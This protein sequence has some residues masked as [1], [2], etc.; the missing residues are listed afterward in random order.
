MIGAA[1]PAVEKPLEKPA[2]EKLVPGRIL[3]LGKTVD[4]V[5]LKPPKDFNGYFPFTPPKTVEAWEKRAADLRRQVQ[6]AV[7]LF[8]MPPRDVPPKATVHGL[9]ERDDFTVER[10]FFESF[11]GC[12]VTGSLFKPKG[13]TGKMPAV[14]CP[15]GHWT[16]GR[17][18]VE[19][20]ANI[21]K[22]LADGSEK[23]EVSGRYP[24]Q[25][26]CVQLARMGCVVFHYDMLGYADSQQV[27]YER[28]HKFNKRD[29]EMEGPGKWSFYSPEAEARL[30]SIMGVQTWNSL[31]AFDW[32][33]ARDDVDAA[34]IAVTGASGGGTQT[35]LL[36]ALEPRIAAAFPAVMV[37]TA[38]QG[39]CTCENCCYLRVGTGNIELA[40]LTAPRPLGMT[41]AN[42][43][44]KEMETKG[45]PELRELYK[46]LGRADRVKLFPALQY[47]HN[48]NRVSR[49]AMYGFFNEHLKLGHT[50]PVDDRDFEPLTREELTVWNE[51][52]PA[53]PT[54]P[55]TERKV[56][57][58]FAELTCGEA[59]QKEDIVR[60]ALRTL[61][62]REPPKKGEVTW[63][64]ERVGEREVVLPSGKKVS[65]QWKHGL[66]ANNTTGEV[67]PA[68]ILEPNRENA[69][70]DTYILVNADKK[71]TLDDLIRLK[72]TPEYLFDARL[73][74]IDIF[75]QGEFT[76]DAVSLEKTPK[77]KNDRDY[78][79]FTYGY[80]EPLV[81]S[82][83]HDIWNVLSGLSTL[84]VE[85]KSIAIFSDV[86]VVGLLSAATMMNAC[87]DVDATDVKHRVNDMQ[88]FD[89]VSF[90]P[91]LEKY[92]GT[93]RLNEFLNQQLGARHR[94]ELIEQQK[95]RKSSK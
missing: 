31:R 53:P 71:V 58:G 65:L 14:L 90:L 1:D 62:L 39:G 46:L 70:R 73:V 78:A 81:V 75:G 26:R 16:N 91:G 34:R 35:F 36:S 21:K 84:N 25:A 23:Y 87:G 59:A 51:K 12:Y 74:S 69:P 37:S 63:K 30:V 57:Q 88:R 18:Y 38:M 44:T 54:G 56:A 80:N 85:P 49:L 29:P 33:A 6:L 92:G 40:A 64:S 10:V 13:K 83:V 77:V 93:K 55:E 2:A 3:P 47:G 43:W 24:L 41:A 32:L 82:R 89:D 52:H 45:F 11:P 61:T 15:H 95:A 66:F 68:I 7:G 60:A 27:S 20:E 48:Y 22:Q 42:D 76:T 50:T 19:T 5:R 94:D 28:A 9:V 72:N 4:D 79:G 8:P 67:V 86:Y 17:F